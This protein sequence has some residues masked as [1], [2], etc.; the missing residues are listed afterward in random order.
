MGASAYEFLKGMEHP[1]PPQ[2]H[3]LTLAERMN[4]KQR[5]SLSSC[6]RLFLASLLLGFLLWALAGSFL[7][8]G[9]M[10]GQSSL[11]Q[12]TD[13][14]TTGQEVHLPA[15]QGGRGILQTFQWQESFVP[16]RASPSPSCQLLEGGR[17]VARALRQQV[18][19]PSSSSSNKGHL[20]KGNGGPGAA[21]EG[22]WPGRQSGP[23]LPLLLASSSP[24][25]RWWPPNLGFSRWM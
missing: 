1:S 22:A 10:G 12:G 5:E 4:P 8:V 3:P 15:S 18:S 9:G 13:M 17:W 19:R 24:S 25:Q 2:N 16:Q 21:A 6:L 14:A 11:A 20:I 7:G 23:C